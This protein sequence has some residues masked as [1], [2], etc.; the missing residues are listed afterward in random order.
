MTFRHSLQSI[1]AALLCLIALQAC[2]RHS[3]DPHVVPNRGDFKE[4]RKFVSPPTLGQPI[5]AC[6]T[7]ITV[8]NFLLGAKIEVFIDGAPAPNPSFIA[9]S[10]PSLGQTHDTGVAFTEGRTIHVTQTF[11]GATSV[12]SN[13]VMVTSHTADFPNGLPKPRLFQHPLFECGHAVL[14]EDVVPNSMVTINTEDPD[15]AGGFKPEANVGGFQASTSWGW[16]WSGVNPQFAL[17]ARVTATAKICTDSSPRSDPEI[18]VTGPSPVPPGSTEK[19]VINGQTLINIWG[20]AGP[21]SDPPQHGAIVTLRD[22]SATVRGQSAV[23]GG[24][25][26][27]LG[28]SPAASAGEKFTVTQALCTE[29]VPGTPTI[30]EDCAALPAPII[31][32][33][34]PGDTTITVVQQIPGA[35]I[36][37]FASGQEIGHSS[38]SQINLSRALNDGETVVVMQRLGKCTSSLVYQI[39]VTCALGTAPGACSSDWPAFRQNGLRTARQVQA[40][41]LGNPYA[42]KTLVVKAHVTA[43]DGGEFVASPVIH[44]G[45]VFIGSNRGHLYAFAANFADGAAPLWQ[46][47]PA[48]ESALE[49]AYATVPNAPCHNPSSVGIAASVAIA[50]SRERGALVILGGP[51]RGRPDDPGGKFGAG[52]GSGRVFALN[53]ANGALAWKTREEIARMTGTTAG[54]LGE[55]HEQIGYSSPLVL[56]NRIYVGIADHCDNPIQNGR[57]KAIDVDS[58]AVDSSFNYQSTSDRG[59]GVWTYVSGGLGGALVT[60]TGNVKHGNAPEPAV[61]NALS[62]VR[63]DPATGA[64]NG[65]IQPVP[66][67]KDSDPDWSAGATLMAASCG[68]LALSTMKDGFSY[69]GNLGPPLAFRWQY[70]SVVYPFPTTDPLKHGD[71]RYHRAGA[72][73]NDTYITMTGGPQIL[74]Q[75]DEVLT[76]Q[77]YR[78]L[79][80]F[81]VCSGAVRW[82]AMLE[83]F[84]NA[85]FS[86][87]D[88]ALGPPTVTGGIVYVGTN[89]GFLL[90]IADPSIWP[91]QGANCTLPTL[92]TSDC[93]AAGYQLVPNPTVLKSLQLGGTILRGE[94]ALANGTVY[95]ANS[96]GSLFRIAPEKSP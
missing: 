67:I 83:P 73:W 36:L 79:H 95:V 10:N 16:N 27:T 8:T 29:S 54:E 15:G 63:I 91:S 33:P 84:T 11:N 38:G 55:F 59:G 19:P 96:A 64:V 68:N 24:V 66:W 13:S 31:K 34:L 47:P 2:H 87:H 1:A 61:N 23:P 88:W 35:E 25:P 80:G 40:S 42:V 26:H 39:E 48:T 28:I 71:I 70:P 69:A 49:S 74:D 77:G 45:R 93:I 92:A 86:Q 50:Q 57:I 21:P 9:S 5:Y 89:R 14:V 32:P 94:P 41:P 76:Y 43:P 81:N 60:T 6:G 72:G 20:A 65:K 75:S 58:G 18:T 4:D 30:V 90:A 53:P 56:G 7:A 62:M 82:M 85:V 44:D 51:D 12:S 52:L 3:K 37:V 78:R 22:S 46:Y 17:G